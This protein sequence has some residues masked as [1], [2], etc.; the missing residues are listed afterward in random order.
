MTD[1]QRR[2]DLL[3][4]RYAQSFASKHA[5]LAEAWRAFVDAGGEAKGDELQQQVH[6]LAGSAP[7]YGYALLGSLARVV[8]SQFADWDISPSEMR[9]SNADLARRLE[10]PMHSLLDCLATHAADPAAPR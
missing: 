5:M 10:T 6:R 7:A 1:S 2:S 3:H 4:A 9:G 8:D